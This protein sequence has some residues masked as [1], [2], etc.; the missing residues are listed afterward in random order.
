ADY[1]AEFVQMD[2]VLVA[3]PIV[4]S[5]AREECDG[6][7]RVD[8]HWAD[9]K[10]DPDGVRDHRLVFQFGLDRRGWGAR[11]R[12]LVAIRCWKPRP[13]IASDERIRRVDVLPE[14]C[15]PRDYPQRLPDS[16]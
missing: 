6:N 2:R 5:C 8:P 13:R 4:R 7:R 11:F 16:H 9:D 3:E 10:Y 15:G 1:L 12:A 14:R